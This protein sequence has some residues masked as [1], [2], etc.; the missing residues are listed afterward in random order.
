MF[1]AY[2][3]VSQVEPLQGNLLWSALEQRAHTRLR[4]VQ[5]VH[6][7]GGGL[8]GC[9][10]EIALASPGAALYS[11]QEQPLLAHILL[12]N[13]AR[14]L[15]SGER[16]LIVL[17]QAGGENAAALLLASPAAVGRYNLLPRARMSLRLALRCS[18]DDFA[19][20]VETAIGQP[21]AQR[22]G[23]AAGA[24]VAAGA[25]HSAAFAAA[26][27]VSA[28]HASDLFALHALAQVMDDEHLEAGLLLSAAGGAGLACVW[29]HS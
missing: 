8:A 11:W 7:I 10:T 4:G 12:H 9:L 29:E 13:A 22:I 2:R 1:E 15:E 17:L 28:Q 24:A 3:I 14:A 6:A 18:A 19:Q 27:R 20:V 26:R 5:E 16:D 23:V 21:L 25:E